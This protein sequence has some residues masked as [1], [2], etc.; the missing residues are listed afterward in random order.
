[1]HHFKRFGCDL[2]LKE[3]FICSKTNSKTVPICFLYLI[4]YEVYYIYYKSY[5]SDPTTANVIGKTP[6]DSKDS[7]KVIL[8]VEVMGEEQE[9]LTSFAL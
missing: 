5:R 6:I 7:D 9:L 1:M 4:F 2:F 3:V 8:T